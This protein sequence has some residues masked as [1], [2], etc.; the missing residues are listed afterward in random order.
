[1]GKIRS[2]EVSDEF[3]GRVEPLIPARKRLDEGSYR[4]RPGGGRKPMDPR[5]TF[6][7]IVFVL[8]TG[9]QWKALPK[10]RFGSASSVHKYFREWLK[11]G[12]FLQLWRAGLAEYDDMEGVAW[13]WQSIDGSMV[14]APLAQESVGRNPTDRGKKW[15]QAA[16]AG[17]REWHPAVAHRNRG[18][19]A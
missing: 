7:G 8:R 5:K 14:K 17:R 2:W 4:R 12:F 15:K 18:K 6:E 1:M 16:C 19:Q 11:A 9:C 3:W 13:K 10:E